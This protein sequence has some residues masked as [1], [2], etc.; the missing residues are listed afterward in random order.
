M[1]CDTPLRNYVCMKT[2]RIFFA[3]TTI[4]FL[5]AC[6]AAEATQPTVTSIPPTLA[7]PAETS[8]AVPSPTPTV[9]TATASPTVVVPTATATWTATPTSIPPTLTPTITVPPLTPALTPLEP[10]R[11][12]G[13][14]ARDIV[15][16]KNAGEQGKLDLYFPLE[17]KQSNA[18]ALVYFH[19]NP[20]TKGSATPLIPFLQKGFIV[21]DVD[22]RVREDDSVAVKDAK[23]AIRFLR[24]HASEFQIDPERMGAY[25]CSYGGFV[26]SML[27]LT[28]N[29]G[30]LDGV[31]ENLDISS[32]VQAAIPIAGF[33]DFSLFFNIAPEER[34]RLA[35]SRVNPVNYVAADVPPMLMLHGDK[36]LNISINHS[37]SLYNKLK[38]VGAS[39]DFLILKG[40]GHCLG[41]GETTP[42]LEET[43]EKMVEFFVQQLKP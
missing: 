31:R 40:G 17:I 1:N 16:C 26:T 36:D 34:A 5:I 33:Y 27:A 4:L 35:K 12:V 9:P 25:G 10:F 43:I 42:T 23:C 41:A 3:L 18:P 24:Q 6:T 38:A 28:D 2:F 32:R 20:G 22:F 19:G 15:Y 37:H 7:P 11:D 21:A 39:V 30:W 14:V 29:D 13:F 8:T